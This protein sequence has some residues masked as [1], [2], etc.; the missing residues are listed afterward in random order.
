MR[1]VQFMMVLILL[2]RR[3]IAERNAR[4]ITR[5]VNRFAAKFAT[6]YLQH[7]RVNGSI[8]MQIHS[9]GIHGAA[10]N[11]VTGQQKNALE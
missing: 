3:S 2:S 5:A 7:I 6:R 11:V 4:L 9:F 10:V 1:L 8:Y